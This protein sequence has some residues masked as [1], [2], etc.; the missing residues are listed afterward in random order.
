[1]TLAPPSDNLVRTDEEDDVHGEVEGLRAARAARGWSQSDAARE[2]VALGRARGVPVAAAPSLKSLLSRWENGHAT[3]DAQYRALLA[4]LYGRTPGQLGVAGAEERADADSA[5]R[6]R[7]AVAEADA[8]VRAGSGPWWQQLALVRRL[9]HRSGAAGAA[10]LVRALV[11]ELDRA[12]LHALRPRERAEVALVLAEA[13]VLAGAH[14]LDRARPHEAWRHHRRAEQA[15][16]EARE[17]AGDAVVDRGV[18]PDGSEPGATV[19]DGAGGALALARAGQAAVL[20]DIGLAGDAVALLEAAAA[21]PGADGAPLAGAMLLARAA[22]GD[23][24]GADEALDRARAAGAGSRARVDLVHPGVP[25]EVDVER[26]HGRALVDLG[27]RPAAVA[28]LRRALRA[29][30]LPVRHRAGVHADLAIALA[31]GHPEESA[32]HARTARELA[33]GIGSARTAARLG[34]LGGPA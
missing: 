20:V 23:R 26:W 22:A 3:P 8:V 4:E 19:R 13:S 27:D 14:A 11:Q 24:A 18:P 12:L 28:P 30:G 1:L 2:I 34:R 7:S 29:D 9:D 32:E 5:E 17:E 25:V 16:A 15:A 31:D 6:L 33:R 21:R 10:G